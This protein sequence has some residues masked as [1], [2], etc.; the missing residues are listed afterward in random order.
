MANNCVRIASYIK[1]KGLITV[2]KYEDTIESISD[3]ADDAET[4]FRRLHSIE[5]ILQLLLQIHKSAFS[6]EMVTLVFVKLN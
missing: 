5:K 6:S 1:S 4:R 2:K 3:M